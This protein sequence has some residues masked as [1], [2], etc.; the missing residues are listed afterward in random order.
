[1]ETLKEFKT[2]VRV[3]KSHPIKNNLISITYATVLGANT[4]STQKTIVIEK[5]GG[6]LYSLFN[7]FSKSSMI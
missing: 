2:G 3:Y 1:M 6:A 4:V 5:N 7:H